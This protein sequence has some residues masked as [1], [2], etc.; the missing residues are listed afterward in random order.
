MYLSSICQ[1]L[2]F[3]ARVVTE[4]FKRIGGGGPI[5]WLHSATKTGTFYRLKYIIVCVFQWHFFLFV[6]FLKIWRSGLY[7]NVCDG[8]TFTKYSEIQLINADGPYC[9]LN[10]K[11]QF[12]HFNY[13]VSVML[14]LASFKLQAN[15][16]L[17]CCWCCDLTLSNLCF[18]LS[19]F[20]L[21]YWV[22]VQQLDERRLQQLQ[23]WSAGAGETR[24]MSVNQTE[25]GCAEASWWCWC[26]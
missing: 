15:M 14:M 11:N 20:I 17:C 4:Q 16:I 23:G 9:Q 21:S 6:I 13:Q 22:S 3:T 8:H 2:L 12:I 1:V 24:S 7:S 19:H 5:F 18:L 26:G 25:V 10:I